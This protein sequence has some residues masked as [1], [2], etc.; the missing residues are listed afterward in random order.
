MKKFFFFIFFVIASKNSSA[1]TYSWGIGS[2]DNLVQLS[3]TG[4]LLDN[5]S[6]TINSDN[7]L[8]ANWSDLITMEMDG[9]NYKQNIINTFSC[10]NNATVKLKII[11]TGALFNKK[12]LKSDH[13]NVGVKFYYYDNAVNIN[14][15]FSYTWSASTPPPVIFASPVAN[16]KLLNKKAEFNALA[17]LVVSFE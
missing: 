4:T 2:G 12:I 11:G 5:R 17:S 8:T 13:D 10:N 15:E 1:D 16:D 7:R 14:E 3:I 9:N 6:C